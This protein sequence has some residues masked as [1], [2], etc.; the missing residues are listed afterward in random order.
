MILRTRDEIEEW[1]SKKNYFEWTPSLKAELIGSDIK[2]S[3]IF[4]EQRNKVAGECFNQWDIQI[5]INYKEIYQCFGNWDDEKKKVV[6]IKK[7]FTPTEFSKKINKTKNVS[8]K[9]ADNVVGV[10][11]DD[12][13]SDFPCTI[14]TKAI[15]ILREDCK[16]MILQPQLSK[17]QISFTYLNEHFPSA[18]FWL[19]EL[20]KEGVES[21][22][23]EYFLQPI[24]ISKIP[25]YDYDK[26]T[27]RPL[28]SEP[29]S[30]GIEI[31]QIERE[32]Q[33]KRLT[34]DLQSDTDEK[35]F[36]FFEKV[37]I[38]ASK[39]PLVEIRCGN[40]LFTESEWKKYLEAS[41]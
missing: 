4:E 7:N 11:F 10:H 16:E 27:I 31:C 39:K 26:W 36:E 38:V 3:L 25:E 34:F 35:L 15:Q 33:T 23:I 32:E 18:K 12:Y 17:Y 29:F 40:V 1:L 13:V 37:K 20:A 8:I 2:I 19:D 41:R 28:D 30:F 9:P 14:E 24:D 6:A 21:T 5:L 22:F